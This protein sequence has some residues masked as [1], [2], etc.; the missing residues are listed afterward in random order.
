M[1]KGT[2]TFE[3]FITIG[4][5]ASLSSKQSNTKILAI[6]AEEVMVAFEQAAKKLPEGRC[7]PPQNAVVAEI[8]AVE[9]D[10]VG[11]VHGVSKK[12]KSMNEVAEVH[13]RMLSIALGTNPKNPFSESQDQPKAKGPA[14]KVPKHNVTELGALGLSAAQL[15]KIARDNGTVEGVEVK[16]ALEELFVVE[17]FAEE[18]N[19]AIL[20]PI[21]DKRRKVSVDLQVF[22]DVYK[23]KSDSDVVS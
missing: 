18:D 22:V 10:L 4:Q 16:N 11:Y 23:L 14:S 19:E 21:S 9:I 3:V 13:W 5:L 1:L 7:K 6:R 15:I 8:G 2:V 17:S 20:R 12:F